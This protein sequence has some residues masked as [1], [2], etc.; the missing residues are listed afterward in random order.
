MIEIGLGMLFVV[1]LLAFIS[2]SD[3]VGEDD[4]PPKKPPQ[5]EDRDDDGD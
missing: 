5:W 4:H 1:L 2:Y 3:K